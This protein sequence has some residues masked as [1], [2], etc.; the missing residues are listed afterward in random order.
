MILIRSRDSSTTRSGYDQ[1]KRRLSS[2]WKIRISRPTLG[3][4]CLTFR[5]FGENLFHDSETVAILTF[6]TSVPANHCTKKWLSFGLPMASEILPA[7][8]S[9]SPRLCRR[10]FRAKS[11]IGHPWQTINLQEFWWSWYITIYHGDSHHDSCYYCDCKLMIIH[12]MVLVMI[13]IT[14]IIPNFIFA[15]YQW[16]RARNKINVILPSVDSKKPLVCRGRLCF[17]NRD[18]DVHHL[19]ISSISLYNSLYII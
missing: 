9:G 3:V 5:S 13:T 1:Q 4:S 17:L 6:T 8:P 2:H 11:Q 18:R 15:I 10:P 12:T 19:Y 16:E 14:I 7:S